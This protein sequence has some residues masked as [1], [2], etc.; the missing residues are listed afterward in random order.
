MCI[1]QAFQSFG[2]Q[3]QKG[4][5]LLSTEFSSLNENIYIGDQAEKKTEEQ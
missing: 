1:G 4:F 2:I 3:I 5:L